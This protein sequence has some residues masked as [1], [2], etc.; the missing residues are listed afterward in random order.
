MNIVKDRQFEQLMKAGHPG[1]SLPSP[2]MVACDVKIFFDKCHFHID[3]ILK[4]RMHHIL[5][6]LFT[7]TFAGTSRSCS[8]RYRRMDLTE[9]SCICGVDS[10]SAPQRPCISLCSGYCRG[11][12]G[13]SNP[14]P[15]KITTDQV[16]VP[17]GRSPCPGISW[18]A[19][20]ACSQQ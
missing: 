9:P 11:S 13:M 4:V 8:F 14:G 10:P 20:R 5:C 12:W 2:M 6:Q 19:G 1:T 16:P 18:H 7:D 3:K 17:H 15:P